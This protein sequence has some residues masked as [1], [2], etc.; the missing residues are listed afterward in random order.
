MSGASIQSK[1]DAVFAQQERN[2]FGPERYALL[3]KPGTYGGF[4]A[5]IGFYTAIA[6]L[7]QN[8]DDVRIN[9]DVTVDAG[10][11]NGNATQNFWRSAENLSIFPSAGFTRWAV[12]Q[13][14]PFR[15]MDIH[16][17][18]NLA[19]NGFGWASGGYIADS[20]VSGVLQPYSQ[21][22]WY[23]RDSQIGS[24]LKIF[25]VEASI[26]GLGENDHP[27]VFINPTIEW[28]SDETES[29]DEGPERP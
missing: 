2:Q 28:F 29:K 19:P 27:M 26:T 13:A 10:W 15:R 8:P 24:N 4:N 3:F 17:D 18:L 23:T 12:A 22:Q 20:R 11:F 1:V 7:G 5:Q 6:G 16:G 9:G 21:Q 25:I 14:A